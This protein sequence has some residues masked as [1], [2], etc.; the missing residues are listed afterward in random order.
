MTLTARN[1]L[2]LTFILLSAQFSLAD[3][4]KVGRAAAAKYF[5]KNADQPQT[6]DRY[7]A[8]E[9]GAIGAGDHIMTIGG[10][11][12]T[13]SDAYDWGKVSSESDVAKWGIDMS[14]RLSQYNSL[15]DYSLRVSYA[16][17]E[18]TN[19]RTNKLIFMYAAT[20]PD[21]TSRFPIYF[22][23]AAGGGVFLNQLPDESPVTLDYSVFLGL[24]L[25]DLFQKTG[26][27]V[28]GGLKNHLQLTSDGQLNATYLST[29]A[30][31][32]F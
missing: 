11:V 8:S 23:A 2:I 9:G 24:R 3:A 20:L 16:E 14:Y 4:P 21:A 5:Q 28:E 29:G 7:T 19:K 26:F 17:Y 25:F 12:F 13:K 27:Y 31:F 10:T 6:A 22:G 32:T 1:L 18:P 30:V 15:L